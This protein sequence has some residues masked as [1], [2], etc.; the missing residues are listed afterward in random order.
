M[1]QI[2]RDSPAVTALDARMDRI[3]AIPGCGEMLTALISGEMSIQVR[4]E[5][6]GSE[7]G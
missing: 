7:Q 4:E 6:V 5:G 3:G 1:K 2:I